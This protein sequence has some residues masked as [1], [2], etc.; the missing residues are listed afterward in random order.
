MLSNVRTRFAPS[1][2]GYMHVGNLRTALYAYLLAKKNGG[3]FIL[4]IEDTDQERYVEGSVDIIYNTLKD[5]GLNWDE[6]PDIG[7]PYAPYVQSERMGDYIKYARKLVENGG[8]Y[9]CFCT[10]EEL[11]ARCAS[12][13][14]DGIARYDGHCKQLS[15]QEVK[16]RIDA[17]APYIIRQKMPTSGTTVFHD[18]V[19]GDIEVDN[20]ELEDQILIKSDG[21]PT[22]NFANVI[23]DHAMGITHVVRGNEYL[24]S[25]PK[26]NLLY[27]AFGWEVPQY[28]HCAPVMKDEHHK[29]SKRNGDASYQDLLAKGYLTAAIINYLALLGWA[30]KGEKEIFSLEELT[31]EFDV[32]GISKSPAI[33]DI[34]KLKFINSEYIR[35]L[36]HDEYKKYAE[37]FIK[38]AV[39]RD[40]NI[41]VL[42]DAL[43]PRTEFFADIPEKLDFIDELP[44]YDNELY[45]NKKMKTDAVT[46]KAALEAALPVLESIDSWSVEGIHEAMFELIAK[47][48]VKNGYMLWPVR[49]ALSGEPVSPGGGIELAAILGK[50]ESIRRI[51]KGLEQL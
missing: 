19:Y 47:L 26:Y 5:A 33:F 10:K 25:A 13:E 17:G 1:P 20:A 39:K 32:S 34:E 24:S 27:E 7:G 28:I 30:P 43:H 49:V 35:A 40:I 29:L 44:K 9:Y 22:Y 18:L 45:F 50:E 31:R 6:G 11:E 15:E 8:A 14:I 36:S 21:M 41:D 12:T 2:T 46:A 48:E 37:P 51:K 38:Q 42:C 3:S 4:R 23:D 16:K